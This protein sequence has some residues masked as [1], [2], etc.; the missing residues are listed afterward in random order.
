MLLRAD[1]GPRRLCAHPTIRVRL[2]RRARCLA[3][4]MTLLPLNDEYIRPSKQ[5]PGAGCVSGR[6]THS[7]SRQPPYIH[8]AM[9]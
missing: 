3:V 6:G 2:W 4:R 1:A 8:G 7:A 9:T 5:A